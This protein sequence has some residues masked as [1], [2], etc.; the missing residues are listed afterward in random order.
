MIKISQYQNAEQFKYADY[1]TIHDIKQNEG[2]QEETRY[3]VGGGDT[4]Y[5]IQIEIHL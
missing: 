3:N 4:K 5:N 1:I 2:K